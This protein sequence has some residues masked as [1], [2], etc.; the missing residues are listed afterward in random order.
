MKVAAAIVTFNRKATLERCLDLVRKQSRPPDE[1]IVV[2]DCSTDGTREFLDRQDDLTVV[3][4]ATNLGAS[5][6]FHQALQL[7]YERGHDWVWLMDDDVFPEASA[8]AELLKAGDGLRARGVRV[9]ALMGFQKGWHTGGE[10]VLPFALPRTFIEALRHRFY[11]PITKAE[12]GKDEPVELDHCSFCSTLFSRD[13]L[14]A[15][16]YPRKEW[17]YYGD[18]TDYPLEI[19]RHGFRNFL[20]PRCVVEHPGAGFRAPSMLPLHACWRNYYMY[21]NQLALLRYH[22]RRLG[23]AKSAACA[24]RVLAG[25]G[26]RMLKEVLRGNMRGAGLIVRGVVDAVRGRM[27]KV[28]AP[29]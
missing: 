27:G 19:A 15:V 5:S 8:L 17:F 14:G 24:V 20:V 7:G 23:F 3:H 29:A 10:T 2:N 1:I 25:A 18:D 26:T 9:G 16:G 4:T 21:R 13:C 22:G 28:I 11:V 12:M 6:S